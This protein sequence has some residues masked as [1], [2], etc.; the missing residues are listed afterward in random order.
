LIPILLDVDTGVDDALA[1]LFAVR[2][3]G[4][5]LRAVTCV[6][7]NVGLDQ[8]VHN[9]L[10]VL[11]IAGAT[12]VRVA[13]GG[14]GGGPARQGEPHG[15]DGLGDL[16]LPPPRRTTV[17]AN[18]V[19]VL[20]EEIMA[21]AE[22]PVLIATGPLTNVAA[23]AQGHPAALARLRG[24]VA[25]G[26]PVFDHAPAED[27][28]VAYDV[29]A[30]HVVLDCG[31]PVRWYGRAVLDSVA[32]AAAQVDLLAT[33]D[34]PLTQLAAA[35]LR[36]RAMRFGPGHARLGDAGAVTSVVTGD[37]DVARYAR[38]FVGTLLGA[39]S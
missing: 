19:A 33:S 17:A 30:A 14:D 13:R 16:G 23:L 10:T 8:V 18:A 39:T 25:V 36:Q 15:A 6:A 12:E 11:D 20:Y 29:P 7:G 27:F 35:L 32:V 22:P 28:N 2:H 24:I 21:A 26:E 5:D 38:L 3:P 9:T 1:L 4:L 37:A 31:A 34:G